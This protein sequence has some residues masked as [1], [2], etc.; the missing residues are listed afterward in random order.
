M[1]DAGTPV[2]TPPATIL[3]VDDSPV[4]LQILVR[5]L[6][7]TGHRLLAAKDG[8][9]ALDIA[10]KTHPDLMLLDVM[11]PGI[12]GFE[13]CRAI[14]ADPA[15]EET[16]VIFL[17]ALGEVSDKVAGLNL[18]AVDY[19]TKPI[20]AEEVV[21]RVS[22]HLARQSL[23][24][25]LRRS[26]DDFNRE[27]ASAADMQRSILP[28]ALPQ[29]PAVRFAAYYRTSRHA[30]GDYYD[31]LPLGPNRFAV[32]VA[33]VSGHGAPAAIV[34]AMIRSVLHAHPRPQPDPAAVFQD[35]NEHFRYLWHNPMFATAVYA[36]LDVE[37]GHLRLACAGHPPPLLICRERGV[38][39]VPIDPGGPLLFAA[40]GPVRCTE[41]D[42]H[43]GDRVVFYTDGITDR[44][45]PDLS[46]YDQERLIATLAG[47]VGRDP[48]AII[49]HV[50]AD[51]D[52]FARGREPEDDQTLLVVGLDRTS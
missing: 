12:D 16:I 46:L 9:T 11:M 38:V 28:R 5:A 33:D 20:Q 23:Q 7:G 42:L 50:V 10:H 34:M 36:V 2:P 45:A 41:I 4:N 51:L 24:R 17:S 31:V 40:L 22:N 18:G 19:I 1:A 32:I 14:K 29:H 47:L 13:V 27:L 6:Q 44:L 49:D 39:P 3:V 8:R 43:P 25:E 30:G 52:A 35:L 48:A 26:R 15:T 37:R 21:A